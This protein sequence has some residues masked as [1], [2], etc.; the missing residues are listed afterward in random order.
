MVS[1]HDCIATYLM[2]VMFNDASLNSICVLYRMK[3]LQLAI[4]SGRFV[5]IE[6]KI[7]NGFPNPN[8]KY[9]DPTHYN[10]ST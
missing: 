7:Q 8:L 10:T 9:V 5:Y 4:I 2:S 6:E 3:I 1:I